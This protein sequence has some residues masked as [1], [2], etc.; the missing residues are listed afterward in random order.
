MLVSGDLLIR[1][2]VHL[3][4]LC[5][6]QMSGAIPPL[7]AD[8]SIRLGLQFNQSSIFCR[9]GAHFYLLELKRVVKADIAPV[10]KTPLP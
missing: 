7:D 6:L 10:V 3:P 5:G 9:L 8:R 2:T 1:H 4:S